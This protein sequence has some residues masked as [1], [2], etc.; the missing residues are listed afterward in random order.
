M[1][2]LLDRDKMES[3]IELLTGKISQI[4]SAAF[5]LLTDLVMLSV[6]DNYISSLEPDFWSKRKS[7][8]YTEELKMNA[9]DVFILLE[10]NSNIEHI[11]ITSDS[12]LIGRLLEIPREDS[13]VYMLG[14]D[15]SDE[16]S[17]E[18][19][20]KFGWFYRINI[21]KV[22]RVAKELVYAINKNN[23]QHSS[24]R[25]RETANLVGGVNVPYLTGR[26]IEFLKLTCSELT[27]KEIAAKMNL[28]ERTID[29]YRDSL[30]ERFNIKSRV[31]L[32]IYAQKNG[33]I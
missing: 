22:A 12:L 9:S 6:N 32:V 11:I 25:G 21:E 19:L 3:Q 17:Y 31:G 33:L 14:T 13:F 10:P 2:S 24:K 29:G 28:S 1:E 15:E 23:Q 16:P 26:E 18:M 20:L 4:T 7:K 30:F 27:Y 5:K 8:Y